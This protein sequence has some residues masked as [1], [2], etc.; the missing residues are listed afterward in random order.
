MDTQT[1]QTTLRAADPRGGRSGLAPGKPRSSPI[2]EWPEADRLGWLES[3]RP[4]QRLKRGGTASHLAP[5]SQADIAN[6]YGMYLDYLQRNGRLDL[7]AN[8]TALVGPE[9][10][11]GFVAELR[12]VCVP[13]QSGTRSTSSGAPLN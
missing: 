4:A 1:R 7:A 6:R 10:V 9:N 3:I 13:S 11:Q 8:A 2:R 12:V 5:V